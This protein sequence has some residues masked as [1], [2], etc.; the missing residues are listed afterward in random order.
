MV[1]RLG[2]TT[3]RAKSPA[4]TSALSLPAD[5]V[6]V[7]L[8]LGAGSLAVQALRTKGATAS[9]ATIRVRWAHG[10]TAR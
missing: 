5:G 4:G 10:M 7:V 9:N 1:T 3:A 8:G 6:L 2:W